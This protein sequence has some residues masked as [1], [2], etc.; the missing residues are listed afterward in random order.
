MAPTRADALRRFRQLFPSITAD[1]KTSWRYEQSPYFGDY[2]LTGVVD[3][4]E[5]RFTRERGREAVEVRP[6]D[7][8]EEWFDLAL[9]EMLVTGRDTLRG[10][11]PES[12]GR[13][14]EEHRNDLRR[15][16]GEQQWEAT[17]RR[18]KRLEEKRM[19]LR[20]GRYMDND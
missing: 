14:V 16:F 5:I 11:A 7:S 10:S 6:A 1:G 15:A 3:S 8:Q 4:M 12:L 17:K 18:L 19:R 9:V 2:A 13:F 20:F